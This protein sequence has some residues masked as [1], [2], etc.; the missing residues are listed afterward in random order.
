MNILLA[1]DDETLANGVQ[2][3]LAQ[4]SYTVTRVGNG[5]EADSALRAHSYD[6]LLLD[7]SLPKVDGSEVLRRLRER[8]DHTPVMILTARGSLEDRVIGLDMGADDY[9]TK[10]FALAELEARI[11][12]L[13][14]RQ[15]PSAEKAIA[16]LVINRTLRTVRCGV[17]EVELSAREIEV[18]ELLLDNINKVVT[19]EQI[20]KRLSG[21]EEALGGNAL[22]VY[23]HRLRKRLALPSIELKT[24]R[25]VGYMLAQTQNQ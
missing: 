13:L 11:R 25:G 17:N 22:E 23:V 20:L 8:G 16:G 12:A 3:A 4:S 5:E 21:N 1:E 24:I 7:L 9:L 2:T 19:R 6:L 15:S 14:R 18:L 10:P